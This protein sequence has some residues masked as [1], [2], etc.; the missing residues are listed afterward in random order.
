MRKRWVAFD[1]DDTLHDFKAASRAAVE[2]V[3]DRVCRSAPLDRADLFRRY[4]ELALEDSRQAFVEKMDSEAFRSRRFSRTFGDPLR[5]MSDESMNELL[6]I[7]RDTL[8]HNLRLLPGSQGVLEV[9]RGA[10]L[11][12][13]VITDAPEDAQRWTLKKLGIEPLVDLVVTS[14]RWGR[15]KSEGLFGTARRLMGLTS[16]EPVLFF[17]DSARTDIWPALEAGFRPILVAA[18]PN[19]EDAKMVRKNGL[20]VLSSLSQAISIVRDFADAQ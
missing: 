5:P 9:A 15:G 8:G 2:A 4:G 17:G 16:G 6:T 14:N 18:N 19:S 12:T 11:G 13:A 3:V 20:T 7:Y 1:L 10:G